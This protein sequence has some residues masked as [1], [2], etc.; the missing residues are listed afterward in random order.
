MNFKCS[1]YVWEWAMWVSEPMHR[2][3]KRRK[4]IDPQRCR[5]SKGSEQTSEVASDWVAHQNRNCLW[6]YP[7]PRSLAFRWTNFL[8]FGLVGIL[9]FTLPIGQPNFLPGRI[10]FPGSRDGDVSWTLQTSAMIERR[11]LG[12]SWTSWYKFVESKPCLKL[13]RNNS[14]HIIL[15]AQCAQ[16]AWNGYF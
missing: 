10:S 1:I 6:L 5:A 15:N 13:N 14:L 8:S 7:R 12:Q 4:Y 3:S 2:V 9:M 16:K 11:R